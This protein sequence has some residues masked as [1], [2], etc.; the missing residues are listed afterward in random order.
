MISSFGWEDKIAPR[1]GASY[2]VTATAAFK[3]YG[4]LGPLL[5]LDQARDAARPLRRRHLVRLLSRARHPND[6]ITCNLSNM[7]GADLCGHPGS[8]RDR[9]V[10]NFEIDRPDVKPMSRTATAPGS[11]SK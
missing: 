3:I 11:T 4:K 7:P 1:L 9:R 10:P 2:D 5:R 8:C 6:P